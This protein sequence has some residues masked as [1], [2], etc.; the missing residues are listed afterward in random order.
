MAA[1]GGYVAAQAADISGLV[2]EFGK[3]TAAI[4]EAKAEREEKQALLKQQREQKIA[5]RDEERAYRAQQEL[6]KS[7]DE[8]ALSAMKSIS[9]ASAAT[10]SQT[11]EEIGTG[12]TYDLADFIGNVTSDIKSNRINPLEGKIA[13][14]KMTKSYNDF[15]AGKKNFS[16]GLQFL[17]EN[18]NKQS[19]LG[20]SMGAIYAS[21]GDVGT[22]TYKIDPKEGIIF[23]EM[24][25]QTQKPV[26]NSSI[27]TNA[28]A[29][30]KA[31]K[32]DEVDYNKIM[33][34][35]AV[36]SR[37]LFAPSGP[38]TQN[39]KVSEEANKGYASERDLYAKQHLSNPMDVARYLTQVGGYGIFS[40]GKQVK[41]AEEG[42][43]SIV[44]E[45][46]RDGV[47][48][49]ANI[50]PE[51][52]EEAMN[53][54]KAGIDARAK[55]SQ[56]I[57][58]NPNIIVNTGGDKEGKSTETEKQRDAADR[59]AVA[60]TNDIK[61]G[62][63]NSS[64]IKNFVLGLASE[65]D[66]DP[67]KSTLI[68]TPNGDFGIQIIS[69][70]GKPNVNFGQNGIIKNYEEIVPLVPKGQINRVLISDQKGKSKSAP[71]N[72]KY[73]TM[74]MVMQKV[75]SDAT[76]SEINKYIKDIESSGKFKVK[77]NK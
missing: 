24:D 27:P 40:Q 10:G 67:R 14:Q 35:F 19:E 73:V 48:L 29:N 77:R 4:Q 12:V 64:N 39:K 13:I 51:M 55:E 34:D 18:G 45:M 17:Q 15:V 11:Y 31:Y 57:S 74:D 43:P 70:T 32:D 52:K 68:K 60:M 16:E 30:Y 6:T 49:P 72:V 61:S 25:P 56:Q 8:Y 22:K 76:Q 50:T 54:M 62:N 26:P 58:R 66:V 23:Y 33:S 44:L 71:T 59:L 47:L 36:A 75:G 46:T 42:K 9:D 21:L 7:A 1:Y 37:T 53:S 63:I 65:Y 2:S 5:E 20:K 38:I 41:E 69:T 3:R 28:F